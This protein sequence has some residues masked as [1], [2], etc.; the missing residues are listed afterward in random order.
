MIEY[1]DLALLRPFWLLGVPL[2][3]AAL[4]FTSAKAGVSAWQRAVDPAL[5]VALHRFGLMREGN[6]RRPWPLALTT[7]I[8]LLA[9]AG[10]AQQNADAGAFRNL[11]GV[12]IVMDLSSSMTQSPAFPEAVRV[13]R[14]VVDAT[15][16]RPTALIVYAADAYLVSPFSTDPATLGTTLSLLTP[17]TAP[18]SGSCL[19]CGLDLAKSVLEKAALVASDVVLV[20]DGEG[21]ETARFDVPGGHLFALA[22]DAEH[23]MPDAPV[24][25]LLDLQSLTAASGGLAANLSA[26]RPVIDAI[27]ARNG[28]A[29]ASAAATTELIWTDYGR[30]LAFFAALPLLL[31]FRRG[32]LQ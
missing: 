12:V 1:G 19:Q 25:Q 9:L 2:A 4:W 20:S 23:A 31:C 5:L 28:G 6:V 27:A 10:P 15:A 13:A 29:S 14:Q 26:P 17:Q 32:V 22:L 18:D 7:L 8:L 11:D 24:P 3:C 21:A 16:T 30:P